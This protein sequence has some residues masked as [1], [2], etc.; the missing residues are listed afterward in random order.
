MRKL[1][2]FLLL[3][4]GCHNPMDDC[5]ISEFEGESPT[6][7]EVVAHIN[8]NVSGKDPKVRADV[9]AAIAD[10]KVLGKVKIG[11]GSL[12]MFLHG[13]KGTFNCDAKIIGDRLVFTAIP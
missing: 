6:L 2:L 5:M 4:T 11:S 13:V 12:T 8:R 3:L 7:S 10:K 9:E 1:L